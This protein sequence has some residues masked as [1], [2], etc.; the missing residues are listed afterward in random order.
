[1]AEKAFKV[2]DCIFRVIHYKRLENYKKAF[3][4]YCC[5]ILEY[6]RQVWSPYLKSDKELIEHVQKHFTRVVCKR[7]YPGPLH[8]NYSMRLAISE[9]KSLEYRR[10]EFDLILCYKI[11][12]GYSDIPFDT[13]FA[14]S[15]RVAT[16]RSYSRQLMRKN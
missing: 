7:L 12:N 2:A 1:M 6:C 3:V 4:I 11:V 13:I 8:L 15:T 9:L 16:S 14:F 10:V 5:P